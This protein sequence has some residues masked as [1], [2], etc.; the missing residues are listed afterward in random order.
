[1]KAT[2]WAPDFVMPSGFCFNC[3]GA[4]TTPI[5]VSSEA[6]L[7]TT[8]TH[9]LLGAAVSAARN[10]AAANGGWVVPYCDACAAQAKPCVWEDMPAFLVRWKM[11]PGQ[12]V[13]GRAFRV[14]NAGK[15][16]LRGNKPFVRILATNPRV[17]AELKALNA[18][19]RIT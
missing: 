7:G 14:L 17:I 15:D 10:A 18:G 4:A 11:R 16:L 3:G 12:T 9:G 8:Q 5:P 19:L 2:I 13:V 6:G 1:M